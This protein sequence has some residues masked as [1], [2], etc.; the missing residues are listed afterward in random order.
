MEGCDRR[1]SVRIVTKSEDRGCE[2][3]RVQSEFDGMHG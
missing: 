1:G 2:N 3:K